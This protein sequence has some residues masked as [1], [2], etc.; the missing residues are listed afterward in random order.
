MSTRSCGHDSGNGKKRHPCAVLLLY[1]CSKYSGDRAGA[2]EAREQTAVHRQ[3]I[4]RFPSKLSSVP[5]GDMGRAKYGARMP[6]ERDMN[7]V[8]S[9]F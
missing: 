3:L 6:A 7:S 4:S 1:I 8:T 5:L 2:L 9:G